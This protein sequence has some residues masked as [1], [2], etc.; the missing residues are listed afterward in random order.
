MFLKNFSHIYPKQ[1]FFILN[2][3]KYFDLKWEIALI[4]FGIF[5]SKNLRISKKKHFE[6]NPIIESLFF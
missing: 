4:L 6:E 3:R 5:S 1:K 2:Y